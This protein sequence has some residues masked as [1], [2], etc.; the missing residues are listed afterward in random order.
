MLDQRP[1]GHSPT[2]NSFPSHTVYPPCGLPAE[3]VI[4]SPFSSAGS[5]L[6]SP[7]QSLFDVLHVPIL[8]FKSTGLLPYV[9]SLLHRAPDGRAHSSVLQVGRRRYCNTAAPFSTS[10]RPSISLTKPKHTLL[11]WTQL[12]RNFPVSWIEKL[13]EKITLLLPEL[14]IWQGRFNTGNWNTWV[15]KIQF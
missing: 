13:E 6:E 3:W 11:P 8:T 4:P 14:N 10:W 12:L 15:G 5:L 2:V 1:K 7:L 9:P